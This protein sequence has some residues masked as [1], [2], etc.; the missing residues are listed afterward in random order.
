MGLRQGFVRGFGLVRRK[1]HLEPLQ[2]RLAGELIF[3]VGTYKLPYGRTQ[4]WLQWTLEGCLR[5]RRQPLLQAQS[6]DV[7]LDRC[8][9]R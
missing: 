7:V 8:Q 3:G 2:E 4:L 1:N 9:S 5:R 6:Q